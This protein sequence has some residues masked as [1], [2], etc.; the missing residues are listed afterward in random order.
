[1]N[2][3]KF[4]SDD[5]KRAMCTKLYKLLLTA[6]REVTLSDQQLSGK[7]TSSI[8]CMCVKITLQMVRVLTFDNQSFDV[9]SLSVFF[10]VY[11]VVWFL[12]LFVSVS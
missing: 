9:V 7:F 5:D 4:V 6:W 10:L 11:D 8:M 1:M 2:H 3:S 12:S